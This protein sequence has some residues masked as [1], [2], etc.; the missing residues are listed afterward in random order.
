MLVRCAVDHNVPANTTDRTGVCP[1]PKNRPGRLSE[2]G[3]R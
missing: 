1:G 3:P 2:R